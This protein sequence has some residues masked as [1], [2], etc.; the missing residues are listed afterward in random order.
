MKNKLLIILLIGLLTVTG[1]TVNAKDYKASVYQLPTSDTYVALLKAVAEATNNTI[2]I[3]VVPAA[4]GLYLV[5]NNQSDFSLP[6]TISNDPKKIAIL[7]F[8]YS[9]AMLYKTTFV[10]YTN[11]TKKVDIANLKS[12][13]SN[14][15]KIE[16]TASL[17]ELFE[18]ETLPS[19]NIEGSLK[20]VDNGTIDGF[21]YSQTSGDK[22]LK[23]LGLKNIKRELYSKNDLSFAINKGK[24]GGDADKMLID[25]IAKLKANGK[26]EQIMGAL[27]KSAEYNDWQP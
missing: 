13:N 17:A 27:I 23:E 20:K 1:F 16:T 6:A 22:T 5:E 8:D 4:R 14:K 12:G 19:T 3:E 2:T 25:G 24:K 15:Y 10:L 18:F 11:K 21:I 9:S 26:F 7:K